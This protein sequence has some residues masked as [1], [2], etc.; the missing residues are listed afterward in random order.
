MGDRKQVG[1]DGRRGMIKILFSTKEKNSKQANQKK[2]LAN[3]CACVHGAF[4]LFLVSCPT[5]CACIC[6]SVQRTSASSLPIEH[7]SA[8][9]HVRIH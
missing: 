2:K 7:S 9:F 6:S 4:I 5:S 1:V 8:V 3:L